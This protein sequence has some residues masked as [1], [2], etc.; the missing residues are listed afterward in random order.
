M[1]VRI[2]FRGLILF[3]FPGP[4]QP[5]AGKLVAEMISALPPAAQ[6]KGKSPSDTRPSDRRPSDERVRELEGKDEHETEIQI[7]TGANDVQDFER[8]PGRRGRRDAGSTRKGRAAN[9]D[10]EK[11]KALAPKGLTRHTR[12]EITVPGYEGRRVR[13]APSFWNHVPSIVRL[14]DMRDS[15]LKL[16]TPDDRFVRNR[17]V[18]NGGTIRVNDVVSWDTGYPLESDVKDAPSAPVEIKFMGVDFRGHAAN[19]CVVEFPDA[20]RGVKIESDKTDLGEQYV[21]VTRRNQLAPEKTVEVMFQNY[22]VQRDKPV[23]WGMDFQL[24]FARLGYGG[25]DPTILTGEEMRNFEQAARKAGFGKL[26][27]ED[28]ATLLQGGAWWP[29]PYI[30]SSASVTPLSP[31]TG[32]KSRPRCVQGTT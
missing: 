20:T 7:A 23:P 16:I 22:E 25:L 1:P 24:M 15:D 8:E 27:D 18:V 31:L 3:R 17:V 4:G 13:R 6:P 5:D 12:V 32:T 30:V 21:P 11:V 10:A 26:F 9:K 29:F 2:Y 28:R 19:E 14:A